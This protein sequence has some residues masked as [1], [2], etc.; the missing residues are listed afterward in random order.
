[1]EGGSTRCQLHAALPPGSWISADLSAYENQNACRQRQNSGDDCRDGNVNES[2]DPDENEVD[3]KEKHSEIFC[4]PHTIVLSES[5]RLCTC[6]VRVIQTY[7]LSPSR[8]VTLVQHDSC[9]RLRGAKRH[10][11]AGSVSFRKAQPSPERCSH[12]YPLLRDLPFRSA[13]GSQRLGE[14]NLSHG[15]GTRDCRQDR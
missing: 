3:G 12:R 7:L 15:A 11:T 14:I 5:R 13:S 8:R 2:H 1:C 9:Y 10:F 4:D 6:K